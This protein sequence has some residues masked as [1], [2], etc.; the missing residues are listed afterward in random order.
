MN[1][2]PMPDM[3]WSAAVLML[4]ATAL[5]YAIPFTILAEAF[6][7]QA[8]LDLR[9]GR[10]LMDATIMN[11]ASGAL[12][13]MVMNH[14]AVWFSMNNLPGTDGATQESVAS[15]LLIIL[16]IQCLISIVVEGIVLRLWER[17]SSRLATWFASLTG[18]LGSYFILYF[19]IR[20]GLTIMA[21]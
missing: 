4:G 16:G 7:I 10:S 13:G 6:V 12:G 14:E 20:G 5:L 21:G 19:I 3:G 8:F 1:G 18:N 9:F 15:V 2:I 11:I 17:D